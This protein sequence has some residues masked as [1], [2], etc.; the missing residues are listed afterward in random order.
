[1]SKS[2]IA[3][4][5]VAAI[6]LGLAVLTANLGDHARWAGLG[7]GLYFTCL[8]VLFLSVSLAQGKG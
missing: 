6:V 2:V 7:E 4:A 8:T 1:M 5:G 3:G